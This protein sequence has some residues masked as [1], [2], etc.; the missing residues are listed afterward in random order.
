MV[1]APGGHGN[2]ELSQMI[3][4][5]VSHQLG[6]LMD[7]YTTFTNL[8]GG[9][10]PSDRVVDGIDLSQ[11]L[12]KRTVTDRWELF[13]IISAWLPP[14]PFS[15]FSLLSYNF[16]FSFFLSIGLFSLVTACP[17]SDVHRHAFKPCNV[18]SPYMTDFVW[19]LFTLNENKQ[20]NQI[21]VFMTYITE[22]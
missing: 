18:S 4:G 19:W 5:Q 7:L 16:F 14:P 1:G 10:I 17:P 9:T 15:L 20:Y 6:S 2:R 21:L 12:F 11:A 22:M 8:A 13:S 3:G